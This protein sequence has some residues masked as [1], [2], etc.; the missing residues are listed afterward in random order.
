MIDVAAA[1]AEVVAALESGGVSACLDIRDLNTPGV[2]VPP[3]T[4][5][6]YRFGRG[7]DALWRPVAAVANTGRAQALTEL[8]AL[9]DAVQH[10]LGG[11]VQSAEP[12]DLPT[13][14]GGGLLPGYQLRLAT[15]IHD[16]N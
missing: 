7:A 3:P 4:L 10:A 8:S 11:I 14:D 13:A 15:R 9:L 12:V 16:D 2:L 6:A 1:A 5:T